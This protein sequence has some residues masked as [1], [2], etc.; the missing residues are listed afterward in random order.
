MHT[1]APD[2]HVM[3]DVQWAVIEPAAA[4]PGDTRGRPAAAVWVRLHDALRDQVRATAG[5]SPLPSAAVTNSA[6]RDADTVPVAA[7]PTTPASGQRPQTL[8]LGHAGFMVTQSRE[9][10]GRFVELYEW[11][12]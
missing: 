9:F 3:T 6:V 1:P 11:R 4:A 12:R 10:S 7:G 8:A 5:R 2:T